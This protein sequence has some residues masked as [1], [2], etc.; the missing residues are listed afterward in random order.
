[1]FQ[2][3]TVA[4]PDRA[5]ITRRNRRYFGYILRTAEHAY[6]LSND[7]WL[8]TSDGGTTWDKQNLEFENYEVKDEKGNPGLFKNN[9][10]IAD[11]NFTDDNNGIIVFAGTAPARF[12][13]VV[14]TTDDAGDTW[15]S[16]N[17]A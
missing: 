16:E 1:M 14:L 10:A 4:T 2:Q 3:K 17:R 5:S 13:S 8:T 12:D 9:V 7:G 6:L 11:I 15:V